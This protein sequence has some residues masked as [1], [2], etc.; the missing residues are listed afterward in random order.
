MKKILVVGPA[1]SHSGYG[2]QTRFAL[3]S[4]KENADKFDIYLSI[5]NWGQ[6]G[7]IHE[8]TEEFLWIRS[9]AQKTQQH[10]QSGGQ[11]DVSLQITIPNEFKKYA[12][13]NIGYT[14]GI[15]TTAISPSWFEPLQMMDKVIVPSVHAKNSIV[16]TVFGNPQGQQFRVTTPVEVVSFPFKQVDTEPLDINL[17]SSKNF[18]AV[19]Q[20]GP[21]KNLETLIDTYFKSFKDDED[22]GLILKVNLASDSVIDK[23][24]T[25]RK[26]KDL[27]A[28]YKDAKCKLY[29]LHGT[30]SEGQ[31][32]SLYT[33]P[34]VVALVNTSHG[35]GF[36]LPMFEAAGNDL[37][38]I[39]PN[40]S[41]HLDFLTVDGK[42][43]FSDVKVQIAKVQPQ[44]VWKG[45]IEEET[46]W[47]YVDTS[48]L[49]K[50]M[51]DMVGG[52]YPRLK[53]RAVKHGKWIRE[54][55]AKENIYSA[56]ID[57][58]YD[59]EVEDWLNSINTVEKD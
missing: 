8:E 55:F 16:T 10:A 50:R 56:F 51:T 48:S 44:H 4:L 40:W 20:W 54:T 31:L 37:P 5:L 21:R 14:A 38:I 11:Y 36:G 6:T 35:E 24:E 39:A 59:K 3:R 2:E 52:E 49:K 58:I 7:F 30:L 29:L 9:L 17:T 1:L 32:K 15:E 57:K 26:I 34:K 41:G 46:G 12:P 13:V 25:T 43:M 47:A 42:E 18:L 28:R 45:V 33:N 22:V 19:S 23:E 27:K 53:A